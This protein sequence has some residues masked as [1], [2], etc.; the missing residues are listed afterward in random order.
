MI[1]HDTPRKANNNSERKGIT[2]TLFQEKGN[3]NLFMFSEVPG[4]L[5]LTY[6][7]D[8]LVGD[9]SSHNRITAQITLQ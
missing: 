5:T 2:Y 3:F 6:G 9:K 8:D 7:L 1:Y 4:S